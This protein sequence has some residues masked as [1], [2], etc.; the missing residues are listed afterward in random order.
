M[1]ADL[2]PEPMLMVNISGEVL[3]INRAFYKCFP[4]I[5]HSD[6][7]PLFLENILGGEIKDLQ[8]LLRA[9]V[10]STT[11][12]PGGLSV[13]K[14]DG[15]L[16]KFTVEF[17]GL[18]QTI[19]E[20]LVLIRF[21][22]NIAFVNKFKKLTEQV[23]HLNREISR[24]KSIN[25]ELQLRH[26]QLIFQTEKLENLAGKDE[27]TGLAN[28]RVFNTLL[29]S[30]WSE[31]EKQKQCFA[32]VMI[33]IDHFKLYNDT[34]GHLQGDICLQK[35]SN[36]IASQVRNEK[37]LV[38]RY[39]GEEFVILLPNIEP[40]SV[41]K[42]VQRIFSN[43]VTLGIPH[44]ACPCYDFVTISAGICCLIPKPYQKPLEH[45][46]KAADR[47]LY[48]AKEQGRNHFVLVGDALKN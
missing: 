36:V 18:S 8:K 20:P 2:L 22:K 30:Y 48:Q 9:W 1:I 26:R 24:Y 44:K 15:A 28:R 34:Y 13:K 16:E 45:F 19:R 41:K 4:F 33:D 21:Q 29:R 43:I 25:T 31:A 38:A 3:W 35:V 5:C 46:V 14:K 12:M 42:V 6:H 23:E 40:E 11:M 32:I 39:G 27:L 10:R 7:G 37:D 47:A 17:V